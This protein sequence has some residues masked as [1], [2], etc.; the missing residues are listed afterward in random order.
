MAVVTWACSLIPILRLED[1]LTRGVFVVLA[2]FFAAFYL[3]ASIRFYQSR[4]DGTAR[5]L[6]RV[7]ILYLPL[8]MILLLVFARFA[9]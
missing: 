9:T 3:L 6:L 2:T 5:K 4:D 7:S 8:Y 1:T